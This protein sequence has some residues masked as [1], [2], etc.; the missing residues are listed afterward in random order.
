MRRDSADAGGSHAPQGPVR[1]QPSSLRCGLPGRLRPTLATASQ[2]F[3]QSLQAQ[4]RS[5]V[6]RRR[7]GEPPFGRVTRPP[8]CGCSVPAACVL[9]RD[10]ASTSS[11][12][13]RT[14]T[15]RDSPERIAIISN[16]PRDCGDEVISLFFSNITSRGSVRSRHIVISRL[17]Q[18]Y[19]RTFRSQLL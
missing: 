11:R 13:H 7:P 16:F 1:H 17:F 8:E 10:A 12:S 15:A 19:L 18:Y 14:R 4:L 9:R 5:E 3:I 6:G 2:N